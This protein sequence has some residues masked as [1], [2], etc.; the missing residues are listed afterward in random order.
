[1]IPNSTTKTP[2][3]ASPALSWTLAICTYN[4]LQFLTETLSYAVV[5]SRRPAE[6]VIVDA[7]DD[8]KSHRAAVQRQFAKAWKDIRLV[9]VAA[10]TRSL[11][12][13]RNQAMRLATSDIVFSL[14]D[15]IYLFADAA[16]RVME[17]YEAD[18]DHQLAMV[19]GHFTL[20]PPCADVMPDA[21]AFTAGRPG[22]VDH[23]RRWLENQFTLDKHFVPYDA[24]VDR[25]PLPPAVRAAGAIESGLINGGRTTVRRAWAVESGWSEMLRYYAT[26]EDSDF[27]YRMSRYGRLAHAT[28]A[29]FFH[30]DGNEGTASQYSIN[31]IRVRNL[32]ALHAIHS[33]ARMRSALRLAQSF[34]KFILLYTVIDPLQKRFTLPT[35]R[36]Y[37]FGMAQ[38]PVFLFWPFKDFR[39]LYT[40]L[41]E[42]MYATRYKS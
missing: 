24:Q 3:D 42:K 40:E 34:A 8:W 17:V 23:V 2:T 31:T 41:Q 18:T 11:T 10:D 29:G 25:D 22:L 38:I 14:D 39:A 27:S 15:D 35:L 5:Q 20:H 28:Q 21:I 12:F 32:M 36:A 1:M 33:E 4:R 16:E 6:V 13:Q 30:A 9:Y 37:L 7:S 26:H 19:A